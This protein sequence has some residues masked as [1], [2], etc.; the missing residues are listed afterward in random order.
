MVLILLDLNILQVFLT[1]F[2]KANADYYV[3][4]SCF[5]GIVFEQTP[6]Y[7][8]WV[9]GIAIGDIEYN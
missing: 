7:W 6:H 3:K 5:I 2:F 4:A 1:F 8:Y 9:W